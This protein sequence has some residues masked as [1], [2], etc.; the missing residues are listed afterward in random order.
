M[1][2]VI[3]PGPPIKK[4]RKGEATFVDVHKEEDDGT[5]VVGDKHFEENARNIAA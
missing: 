3:V 4:I 5:C 2:G 1:L